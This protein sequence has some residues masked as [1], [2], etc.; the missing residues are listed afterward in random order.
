MFWVDNVGKV[1]IL[2]IMLKSM[3][4]LLISFTLF[5]KNNLFKFVYDVVI[6][7]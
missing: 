3:L 4:H 7:F 1:S 5:I 6:S 2:I